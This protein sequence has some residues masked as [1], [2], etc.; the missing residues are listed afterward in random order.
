[1]IVLLSY[2]IDLLSGT[3][4]LLQNK[5]P[6]KYF[7]VARDSSFFYRRL[8]EQISLDILSNWVCHKNERQVKRK[9]I[10]W[11]NLHWRPYPCGCGLPYIL[12]PRP[13]HTET[14]FETLLHIGRRKLK[15]NAVLIGAADTILHWLQLSE[16]Q[17]EEYIS[18]RCAMTVWIGLDLVNLSLEALGQWG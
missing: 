2:R 9:K 3:N 14:S 7:I 6:F 16:N 15:C 5:N 11:V 13:A 1:M 4:C 8:V 12:N 18:K 10:F 17:A